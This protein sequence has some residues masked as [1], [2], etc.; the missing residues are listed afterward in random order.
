VTIPPG[1]AP[2]AS[3]FLASVAKPSTS[4]TERGKE[5]GVTKTNRIGSPHAEA[6][7]FGRC[8]V[9]VG[10]GALGCD[11]QAGPDYQGEPLI[12]INGRVE[13]PLSVGEVEVGILWLRS[14]EVPAELSRDCRVEL[15]GE[16]PSACVAACG[17]PSC[18]DL[19]GLRTWDECSQQCEGPTGVSSINYEENVYLALDA[20]LGQRTAVEGEF[21][22]QFRL[23]LLEPPPADALTLSSSGEALGIGLFIAL[24]PAGAPFETDLQQPAFPPWLLGGS[25]SHLLLFSEA[26]VTPDTEWGQLLEMGFGPGFQL[27]ELHREAVADDDGGQHVDTALLPVSERAA[28]RVDLTVADPA[29]IDWPLIEIADLARGR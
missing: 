2:A 5:V 25:G 1:R 15:S 20:A 27:V 21:P 14:T 23:D 9:W 6:G 26:A 13:A 12:T 29:T 17:T 3:D 10:L 16:T 19:D 4:R 24:D 22:A 7:W 28:M 18:D 8:I 11:A